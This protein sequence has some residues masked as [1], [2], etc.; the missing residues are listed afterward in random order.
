MQENI[1]HDFTFM[2]FF[3]RHNRLMVRK[4]QKR[5]CRI[6]FN[7]ENAW[8]QCNILYVDMHLGFTDVSI[9]QNS[10]TYA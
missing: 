2:E 1:P 6:G 7:W 9:C 3:T 8:S 5:D 10:A 4:D